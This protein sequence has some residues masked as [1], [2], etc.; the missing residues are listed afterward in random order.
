MANMSHGSSKLFG[1]D[2]APDPIHSIR[3]CCMSAWL[4]DGSHS[5]IGSRSTHNG[6]FWWITIWSQL[7]RRALVSRGA[8]GT[9]AVTAR[10]R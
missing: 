3:V 5:S 10:R 6:T 9:N 7:A 4:E 2:E 8:S 1:T